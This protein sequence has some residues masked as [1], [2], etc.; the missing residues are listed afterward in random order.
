MQL[1]LKLKDYNLCIKQPENNIA[2]INNKNLKNM[3]NPKANE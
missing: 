3:K 1:F 2:Q